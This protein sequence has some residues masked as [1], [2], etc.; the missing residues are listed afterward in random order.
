[1]AFDTGKIFV[2][3]KVTGLTEAVE[4][5]TAEVAAMAARFLFRAALC[6]LRGS[7]LSYRL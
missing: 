2:D 1:M 5:L 4:K 3:G 7:A 6:P